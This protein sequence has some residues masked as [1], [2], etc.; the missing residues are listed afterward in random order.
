MRIALLTL[1]PALLLVACGDV[2][3]VDRGAATCVGEP[4]EQPVDFAFKAGL[5]WEEQM[6]LRGETGGLVRVDRW[7]ASVGERWMMAGPSYGIPGRFSPPR[8]DH[9]GRHLLFAEKVAQHPEPER[10]RMVVHDIRSGWSELTAGVSER[11]P[12]Y[13]VGYDVTLA[14]TWLDGMVELHE[15]VDRRFEVVARAEAGDPQRARSHGYLR[16]HGGAPVLMLPNG[17]GWRR[18]AGEWSPWGSAESTE[19]GAY[20]PSSSPGGMDMC[21]SHVPPE[22]GTPEAHLLQAQKSLPRRQR[23]C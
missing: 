20:S 12:A 21:F 6:W 5:W 22:G 16:Q 2:C 14:L 9:S 1:A 11:V 3:D 15:L 23:L 4:L 17:V 10:W 18:A 19:R 7:P 13:A 8:F